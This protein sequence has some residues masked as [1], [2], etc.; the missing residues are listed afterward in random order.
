MALGTKAVQLILIIDDD[1]SI[2]HSLGLVL[3]Q[4]GLSSCAAETPAAALAKLEDP[5]VRLVL[6]DMNFSRRTGGEEGLDLLAQIQA[7]RPELPV[8]LITA[9]GSIELAVAGMKAGAADFIT[10]P[11]NNQRVV[12]AVETTLSIARLPQDR[13]AVTTRA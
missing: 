3:K 7:R 1:P 11:W 6:Q 12:E 8:V 10:K 9:W 13:D 4:A 2:L 5:A